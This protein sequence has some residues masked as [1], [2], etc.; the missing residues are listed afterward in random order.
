MVTNLMPAMQR[1]FVQRCLF[2]FEMVFKRCPFFHRMWLAL[3]EGLAAPSFGHLYNSLVGIVTCP[4]FQSALYEAGQVLSLDDGERCLEQQ[5]FCI[6]QLGVSFLVRIQGVIRLWTIEHT[7]FC[8]K[9]PGRLR[10][11]LDQ[12][13]G[14]NLHFNIST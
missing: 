14:E 8:N 1:T 5:R 9:G 10:A 2:K 6:T 13:N 11:F 4:H 3:V 12:I 7:P